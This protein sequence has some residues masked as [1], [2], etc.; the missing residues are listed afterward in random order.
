MPAGRPI[1]HAIS[2]AIRDIWS[3]SGPRLI[4]MSAMDLS[5]CQNE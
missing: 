5:F 2:S 4:T 1:T 3:V